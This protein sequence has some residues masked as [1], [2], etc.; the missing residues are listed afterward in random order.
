MVA[1]N[2]VPLN[3]TSG[4][5]GSATFHYVGGTALRDDSLGLVH[6]ITGG[7]VAVNFG[8][9]NSIDVNL[10]ST[11]APIVGNC[12][13]GCISQLY[14]GGLLISGTDATGTFYNGTMGGAFVGNGEGLITTIQLGDGQ[15]IESYSGTAA[16]ESEASA[17]AQ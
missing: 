14:E 8:A 12:T 1:S 10:T 2:V 4:L 5:I 3:A 9:A 16:F 17:A 15:G 6:N 13:S 11:L 7:T